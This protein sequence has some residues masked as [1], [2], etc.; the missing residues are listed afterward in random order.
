MMK[1]IAY[2]T[3]ILLLAGSL[4]AEHSSG[5][6]YQEKPSVRKMSEPSIKVSNHPKLGKILT[7]S[8]GMTLYMFTPDKSDAS[9][10]YGQ[11]A[12]TWPPL[13]ISSGKPFLAPGIDGTL[14]TKNRKDNT[15]QVTYNGMPLYYYVK[16]KN[17]GDAY[18]QDIENKW[19]VI[20][21]DSPKK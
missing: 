11:C 2:T 19:F 3:T 1:M 18:G 12:V 15:S 16:D 9:T 10:C 5:S 17:P 4:S 7:D 13:L 8:K 20:N 21:P 6:T 14:D